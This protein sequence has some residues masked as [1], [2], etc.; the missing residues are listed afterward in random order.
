MALTETDIQQFFD[1]LAASAEL[2]ERARAVILA[3]DFQALP[4]MMVRLGERI[5][6]LGQRMDQ[7]TERA[8]ELTHR[9]GQ[10]T[11]R[12]DQMSQRI[13]G[14]ASSVDK[15]T[16]AIASID[17][18]VG[19]LEGWRY[20][21]HYRENLASH[22][23]RRFRKPRLLVAGN[24]PELVD[25]L[26]SDVVTAAEWT[27]VM[28]LDVLASAV[29]V[30]AAGRAEVFFAIELSH[31]VDVSDVERAASRRDI[32][33]RVFDHPVVGCV[34]GEAILNDAEMRARELG[35]VNLRG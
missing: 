34:D 2:R 10:L 7:L 20:E 1:A 8:E 22:L 21:T 6:G 19:R 25:A 26:D 24:V 28:A 3:D 31:V 11:E 15:L 33:G 17:G 12:M 29:D 13:D 4:G 30:R 32:L 5:D 14:L 16:A 18:R 35:V 23:V 9:M 27:E